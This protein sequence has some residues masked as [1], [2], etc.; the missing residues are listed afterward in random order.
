MIGLEARTTLCASLRC[1]NAHQHVR[2]PEPQPTHCASLRSRNARQ[3]FTSHESH[4]V[5]NVQEK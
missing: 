3:D 5:I 1:L 2:S 4:F